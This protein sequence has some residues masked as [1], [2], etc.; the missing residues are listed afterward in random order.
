MRFN[1]R[2]DQKNSV[3]LFRWIV[4]I[5][6]TAASH[7]PCWPLQS[8]SKPMT[9]W[10][11]GPAMTKLCGQSA[12]RSYRPRLGELEGSYPD[13]KADGATEAARPTGSCLPNSWRYG[14]KT[15]SGTA[16]YRLHNDFRKNAQRQRHCL[17]CKPDRPAA[18]LV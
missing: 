2:V 16:S 5:A 14:G 9:S 11:A 3:R 6:R 4:R 8:S 12:R 1:F 17:A 18:P 13:E 10:M 15:L 7:L